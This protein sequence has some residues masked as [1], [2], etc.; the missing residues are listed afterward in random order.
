MSLFEYNQIIS[1]IMSMCQIYSNIFITREQITKFINT[2]DK[3]HQVDLDIFF[4]SHSMDLKDITTKTYSM[5]A[6]I[7]FINNSVSFQSIIYQL[8]LIVYTEIFPSKYTQ[9]I[10]NRYNFYTFMP[11]SDEIKPKPEESCINHLK[12]ILRNE[13]NPFH[14]DYIIAQY[15]NNSNIRKGRNQV[16][17]L[18]LMLKQNYGYGYR[19]SRTSLV[20]NSYCM[21]KR[22]LSSTRSNNSTHS[23]LSQPSTVQSRFSIAPIKE[24]NNENNHTNNTNNNYSINNKSIQR[25]TFQKRSRSYNMPKCNSNIISQR[26]LNY[27]NGVRRRNGSLEN[28]IIP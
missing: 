20:C 25:V 27:N 17:D 24:S 6:F 28:V 12:R 26:Y 9:N 18:L 7:E 10:L 19:T 21:S 4:N 16:D 15:T 14:Y 2:I 23:K 5:K 8:R 3:T 1:L 13:P 11:N 22:R